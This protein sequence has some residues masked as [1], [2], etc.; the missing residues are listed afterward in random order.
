MR[1]INSEDTIA[2]L[3]T[4]AGVGAVSV[5]RLS[6]PKSFL[7]ADK[8]FRGKQI[9][10]DAK[11]HTLHYG[12][13]L[14]R[15]GEIVDDVLVSVFRNPN[16]FTGEDS[17]EISSHGSPYI[18]KRILELL[19]DNG[20]RSAY[21]GEFTQRAF[22]NGRMDLAQA[23]AVADIINAR[24]EASLRGARNQIDGL[25]SSKVTELKDALVNVSSLMELELDFAEEDLQ[26]VNKDEALKRI[27][28]IILELSNLLKTYSFGRIIRDGIH[29]AIV[30]K[31][32]VGKSSLLNYLLKDSRAIVSEIP[33]TTRDVITEDFSYDGILFK[34]FDTAGIR[35]SSDAIE[36]EGISRSK[37]A[38]KNADIALY[39]YD[40]FSE[41]EED[42]Y[43]EVL[44]TA[45]KDKVILAQ[46]KIDIS[47]G[48]GKRSP[49]IKISAKKGLGILEMLDLMKSRAFASN[50]YTE[51]SAI[52]TNFR[53]YQALEGARQNLLN[54]KNSIIGNL[55]GEFAA[56]DLRNAINSLSEIIGVVTSDDI[57]NNIFSKFCIGK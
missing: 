19:I 13:I 28:S 9:L 2:A 31:P 42:L 16:S 36:L 8:V 14:N 34:L 39:L 22:L 52:I 23:E 3:A 35:E 37:N 47:E 24:T 40:T 57:L 27:D 45:G 1:L 32:N 21:A 10:A 53:H 11:S 55:S 25:L 54:A 15:E 44:K 49:D 12:K 41:F 29:V 30:G 17:V 51:N 43:K 6:G 46:N 48:D 56:V 26:F 20:A 5:I 7:I 4:P 33:G 38:L 50:S 18:T